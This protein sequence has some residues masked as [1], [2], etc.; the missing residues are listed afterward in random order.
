MILLVVNC[1]DSKG[2]MNKMTDISV[3]VLSYNPV[4][5][6]LKRTLLSIILQKDISLEIVVADDGSKNNYKEDVEALFFEYGFNNYKYVVSK[7]NQGTVL[8]VTMGL[9]YCES[10]YIKLL[11]PGDYLYSDMV[12]H[13]WLEFM[14][15]NHYGISFG[16]AVYYNHESNL[17]IISTAHQPTNMS[18]YIKRKNENII[19]KNYLEIYDLILGAS[20]LAKKDLMEI[21]LKQIANKVIFTEDLIY[22]LMVFD[23]IRIYYYNKIV[24]WYE[25][26]S[27]VSDSKNKVWIERM[28]KDVDAA[29]EILLKKKPKDKCAIRFHKYLKLN[30]SVKNTHLRKLIR[31]FMYSDLIYWKIKKVLFPAKTPTKV[32]SSFYNKICM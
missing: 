18:V 2:K 26:A 30:Y 15:E 1:E 28:Q 9:E 14:N 16:D 31:L 23:G 22:R 12:L 11:S 19:R 29:N 3:L 24:I 10:Q 6:K 27:G 4:W 20:L 25:Y 8:N 7:V 21:Y 5:E 32:N 13:N 17:R